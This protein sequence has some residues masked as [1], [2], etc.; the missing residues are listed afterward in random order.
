[1]F[2]W[3]GL[4][5]LLLTSVQTRDTPILLGIFLL[6]AATVVLANLVTDLVYGWLDPRIRYR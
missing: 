1:M 5:R 2:G 3:P 6:V 4:S